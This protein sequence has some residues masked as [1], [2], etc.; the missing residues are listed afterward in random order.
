[1]DLQFNDRYGTGENG[2][3]SALFCIQV[4]GEYDGSTAGVTPLCPVEKPAHPIHRQAQT[5]VVQAY[6]L[7]KNIQEYHLIIFYNNSKHITLNS[8]VTGNFSQII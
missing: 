8:I 7:W 3:L 1:M 6:Q 5:R 2:S 4:Q